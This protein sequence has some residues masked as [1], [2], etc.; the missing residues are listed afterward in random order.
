MRKS[1]LIGITSGIAAYKVLDLISFLQQ[2]GLEVETIMTLHA[3]RMLSPHDV[4]EKTGKKVYTDLFEKGFDPKKILKTRKVRHI[5]L[6]DNARVLV[7]APA[8]ANVLAKLSYGIAD[9]LLTTTVLAATCPII[10]CP[11]MNIHMYANP[12]VQENIARLKKRGYIIIEPGTGPLACGYDG[13]GRLADTNL[14]Q[15]EVLRQV[16]CTTSL[17]GKK[18]I[19]TAGGTSEAIDE[20]RYITNR[21]SGKMGIALAEELYMRGADVLVLRAVHSILPRYQMPEKTF[22]TSEELF[23][24]IKRYVN[25]YDTMY[26]VA[27]VSD[28]SVKKEEGKMSSEIPHI[29]QLI[30][31][32]KIIEQIKILNPDIQL[33]AFK[34]VFSKSKKEV[35]RLAKEKLHTSHADGII[36]N[37][38]GKR[39]GGFESDDNEVWIVKKNG[40]IQYFSLKPKRTLAKEIIDFLM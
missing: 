6:A 20:V 15:E 40:Q 17:Q 1:I 4:E 5:Q 26:H 36:A 13:K 19:V 23:S 12:V 30:P 38:V 16:A 37:D 31:Q 29:L 3:L 7:I 32:E 39:T 18:I 14:I 9:D 21:S 27:A 34:A 8:T 35:L 2:Q 11:S 28:F 33:F 25:Y 22:S 10:L 24:L